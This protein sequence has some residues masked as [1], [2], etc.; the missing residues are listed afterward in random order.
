M[1]PTQLLPGSGTFPT[2][3]AVTL[4]DTVASI[5]ALVI[6]IGILIRYN[7][8][9][10]MAPP[11]FFKTMR[12]SLGSKSMIGSFF[13]ELVNR[14]ILQRDLIHKDRLR[15][16]THL[17]MFWGFVGLSVTTTLDYFFNEPGNYIPLFG[18]TLSP[19]RWLGNVSGA[20]MVCG[21]TVAIGRLILVSK[22]RRERT[23][24]DIWFTTL[25]FL[26]GVTGFVTEYWGDLAHASNPTIS[27][28]AAYTISLSASLMII[29][30]YG[31]H[32][33]AVLLLLITAP[34]SAFIHALTVPSMRYV[35][36]LGN[37]LGLKR[38][39]PMNENRRLKEE[40][41]MDDV[42]RHNE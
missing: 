15:R 12:Q 26:A 28:A 14:V 38:N 5:I 8:W 29:I 2:F 36:K 13:S 1:A 39:K 32:L 31:V 21:A 19:I 20:V 10:K 25:L 34:I 35:D 16:I 9:R 7:K 23:F 33:A 42:E 6:V 18:G 22:F 24:G 3:V 4:I 17:A 41:L 11:N 40:A 30:P 37:L 27:P